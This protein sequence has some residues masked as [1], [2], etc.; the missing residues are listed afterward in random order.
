MKKK[1]VCVYVVLLYKIILSTTV[2]L[3]CPCYSHRQMRQISS[4][5]A[6]S[7]SFILLTMYKGS[8]CWISNVNRHIIAHSC[9]YYYLLY[10]NRPGLISSAVGWVSYF[11]STWAFISH[12]LHY[13]AVPTS[14]KSHHYVRI[15]LYCKWYEPFSI[16][17]II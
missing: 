17:Y 15:G 9:Y 14:A 13:Y 12:H 1:I 3:L 7:L 6:K 16:F 10:I 5:I 4:V 11:F 8:A 2:Y